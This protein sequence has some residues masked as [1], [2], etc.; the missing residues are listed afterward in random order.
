MKQITGYIADYLRNINWVIFIIISL[1]LSCLV[2]YNYNY[3]LN[4]NILSAAGFRD[5]FS[6]FY[7]LYA[8][9]FITTWILC[10][11]FLLGI[12]LKGWYFFL[13]LLI[14]PAIFSLKVSLQVSSFILLKNSYLNTILQWPLKAFVTIFT[15]CLLWKA[16][17]NTG[18]LPGIRIQQF[19]ARPYFLL[20]LLMLPVVLIA[21][22]GADFQSIYPKLQMIHL[23]LSIMQNVIFELCYGL[24]FFTIELF[25]RGFLI[26]AFINYGG[27]SAILPMAVFYC[28]IHFG[29][30]VA[31][32]IS[33]YFGGII[34]GAVVYNTRSIW[35]GLIVHLGIAWMMEI[36]GALH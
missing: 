29:K 10:S 8:T 34:L 23:P 11:R 24:D 32:C 26:L 7:F 15:I 14:A 9:A 13:L 3:H 33:S 12:S 6:G 18:F 21:G 25:F 16:G 28:T 1:I 20:L 17:K 31:E 35:G 4:E 5:R 19:N 36:A 30:P 22:Q 27:K 2:W